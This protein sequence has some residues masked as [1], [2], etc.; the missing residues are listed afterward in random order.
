MDYDSPPIYLTSAQIEKG[1]KLLWEMVGALLKLLKDIEASDRFVVNFHDLIKT[2]FNPAMVPKEL[3]DKPSKFVPWGFLVLWVISII[4]IQVGLTSISASDPTNRNDTAI[5]VGLVMYFLSLIGYYLSRCFSYYKMK[6]DMKK[7]AQAHQKRDPR[8]ATGDMVSMERQSSVES[9]IPT[10]SAHSDETNDDFDGQFSYKRRIKHITPIIEKID[11][12][13]FNAIQL[14]VIV[15][16][17]VQLGSFPIRD[18]FRSNT[19]LLSM[20]LPQNASS[21]HFIDSIRSLFAIFSTGTSSNDLDY[22][23]FIICWWLTII[24]VCIAILFTIIQFLLN[25]E[26]AADLISIKYQKEIKKFITGPWII[27]F[28]PLINLSYLII[29]NSFLEPLSCLSSNNT[30]IWPSTFDNIAQ[31]EFDR[32]QECA[33]IYQYQPVMNSWY[34]LSGF[35]IAY[36]LFTIC[37]TAQEPKPQNGMVCYTS[38]S[39]LFTKNGSIILLLLYALSPTKDTTTV[40]GVL[41]CII[42]CLMIGYNVVFGS[43]YNVWVNM[44]RTLFYLAILWMCAVVTYYTQPSNSGILLQAGSSVWGTIFWGWLIIWV[45]YI[46]LYFVVIRKWELACELKNL[47]RSSS[48]TSINM[49]PI[50]AIALSQ[51][52]RSLSFPTTA[53]LLSAAPNQSTIKS[54]TTLEHS[55]IKSDTKSDIAMKRLHGPRPMNPEM[56]NFRNDTIN[57]NIMTEKKAISIHSNNS[58]SSI[59]KSTEHAEKLQQPDIG[60]IAVIDPNQSHTNRT[61]W[62]PTQLERNSDLTVEKENTFAESFSATNITSPG[63]NRPVRKLVGPRAMNASNPVVLNFPSATFQPVDGDLTLNK[64]ATTSTLE[65]ADKNV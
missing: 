55:T 18:L 47:R 58:N 41:A 46:A 33:G 51:Q 26:T 13:P 61:L 7:K 6:T 60:T 11:F 8:V 32:M 10:L 62:Q 56:I 35:S 29:L 17:F 52:S 14:L 49:D 63:N 44:I 4:V 12:I 36:L 15:T 53:T 28:L 37:R 38:R 42:V 31:S 27:L 39:E 3:M 45:V 30:P 40:R 16:E 20:Q 9:G 1:S 54:D 43:T 50:S 59:A 19:F 24:G 23:K 25:W 48:S 2:V 22:I 21:K 57:F 65:N 5:Q 64:P 34:S